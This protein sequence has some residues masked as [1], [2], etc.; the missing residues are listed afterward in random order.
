LISFAPT[1]EQ[2]IARDAMREFARDVVRPAARDCDEAAAVPDGLLEQFWQLGLTSTQIPA[3]HGG[4][5][6]ENSPLMNAL[7]VE[8][9]AHGDATLAMAALAPS[10]FVK[11]IAE[12]G[13]DV[14]K[15]KYLP[16]FTGE[17][18]HG[19]SL[20]WIEPGPVFDPLDLRTEAARRKD[21]WVLHGEKRFVPLAARAS[22]F[23]AV[24]RIAGADA[25]ARGA[26]IGAFI[27]ERTAPGVSLRGPERN[28]GLRALGTHTVRLDGVEVAAADRLG[29]DAGFDAARLVNLTRTALGAVMV[30]LSRAVLEYA[31]PYAKDRVAFGEPIAQKQA[32]AFMLSDMRVET[33]ASRLL[34]WKAASELE[35]RDDATRAA[36]FARAYTAEQCMKI[37]DNGVQVLG[38]HG[39]IRDHPAEMWYRN[40][41]TLGVLEG[42][43][44]I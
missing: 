6:E 38:G 26:G 37:A 23:L 5:G 29:G 12:Q 32:I 36:Q 10:L 25:A 40:A 27:V 31:L 14:Q 20:A 22:H 44:M 4:A 33:D 28:L 42:A 2:E 30:G 8:E 16:L 15:K 21:G 13:T 41:R 19:A 3:E 7:I 9:L 43:A 24:A 17:K 11:P 39:F 34:V 1:E 18:F 35:R